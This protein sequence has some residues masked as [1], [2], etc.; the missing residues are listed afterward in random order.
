MKHSTLRYLITLLAFFSAFTACEHEHFKQEFVSTDVANFWKAYDQINQTEDTLLQE[1]LLKE[2]YLDKASPGLKDLIAVKRY[3]NKDF[4][5]GITS[6]PEF[7]SSV[8]AN[9]LKT[10][11]HQ[12]AINADIEKLKKLYPDLDPATIYFTI[13]AFRSNGTIKGKNVLISSELALASNDV[14]VQ[15]LPEWRQPFFA[16]YKP[17]ENL[18]LL[19]THEY[20]HTQQ[21]ELVENLLSTCLYEGVAEFVSCKATGKASNSP[22]ISFGKQNEKKVVNKFL[23]DLYVAENMYNWLW[24]ENR[25]ELKV[26]DL[27]YYIGYEISERYYEQATDKTLA[28]KELIELDYHDENE[29]ERIVDATNLLPKPVQQLYDEYENSRPTVKA[30]K[31]F[32]NGSK[33]VDPSTKSISLT[34]SEPLNGLNTGLDFGPLGKEVYPKV[35]NSTRKW[36]ADNAS[37]SF[38]V[39]LEAGKKYQIQV[40]NFRSEKGLRLKPYLIEFE[41]KK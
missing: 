16:D 27:G 26:R 17:L 21:N 41:T 34:F 15:E 2:L 29:V 32:E 12:K 18:A 40:S 8:K 23:E 37:Y 6:Y 22:A 5:T 20:I 36:G 13:G 38:G 25:N 7:W 10:K 3:T 35:D 4:L 11:D 31:E 1:Q 33:E 24:G 14:K 39:S 30:I 19:C 28:I 9:T